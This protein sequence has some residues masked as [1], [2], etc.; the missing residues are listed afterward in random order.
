[1]HVAAPPQ[2]DARLARGD[3]HTEGGERHGPQGD[4]TLNIPAPPT[5]YCIVED[6]SSAAADTITSPAPYGCD[7]VATNAAMAATT[8][9]A[10]LLVSTSAS[11]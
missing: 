10:N 1:V 4:V 3:M 11:S 9:P 7:V 8:N 5:I 6:V 2:L